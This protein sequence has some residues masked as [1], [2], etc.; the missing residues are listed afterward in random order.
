MQLP[1]ELRSFR[2]LVDGSVSI[3]FETQELAPEAF[4][5]LAVARGNYGWITFTTSKIPP[6][7]MDIPEIEPE[8]KSDRTPSQ[9][10]R[11]VLYVVHQE[12]NPSIAFNAF[13]QSEVNKI[14]EHYKKKYLDK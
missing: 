4:V 8:F 2:T 9:R 12:T 6:D 7:E 1:G 11:G 5:Q 3:Q 13:Y 10:L 14:I